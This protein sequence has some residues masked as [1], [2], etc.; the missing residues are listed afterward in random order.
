MGNF[1]TLV[2]RDVRNVLCHD[3]QEPDSLME[4]FV[5]FEIMQEGHGHYVSRL[6]M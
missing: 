6:V 4:H 5:V 2:C 1:D 3:T